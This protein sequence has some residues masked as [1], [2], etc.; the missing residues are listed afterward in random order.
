MRLY[1]VFHFLQNTGRKLKAVRWDD[2][3][4]HEN[5]LQK[6]FFIF[7][8]YHI[9]LKVVTCFMSYTGYALLVKKVLKFDLIQF[10]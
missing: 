7:D 5:G 2:L 6:V 8:I 9:A 10:V 4:L 3:K 1:E